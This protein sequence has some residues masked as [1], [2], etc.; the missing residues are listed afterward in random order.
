MVI[1]NSFEFA[2]WS[3]FL[4]A[5]FAQ[6]L[7]GLQQRLQLTIVVFSHDLRHD[8]SSYRAGRGPLGLL[9]AYAHSV[10]PV[11]SFE[12]T[13]WPKRRENGTIHENQTQIQKSE[14]PKNIPYESEFSNAAG[15]A[16]EEEE[17]NLGLRRR[18]NLDYTD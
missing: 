2:A 10:W 3:I 17:R 9:A 16:N 15:I 8:L 6:G 7:V 5:Q 12:E 4:R 18:K 11:T 13:Q 1:L 14:R